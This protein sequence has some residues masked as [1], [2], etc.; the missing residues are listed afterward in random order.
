MNN[1]ETCIHGGVSPINLL[2]ELHHSQAGSGRHR[3]P[4][5]AY[6]QGFILGSSKQWISYSDYCLSLNNK[7]E[8]IN[9]SIAPSNI[10]KSLGGNQGGT[11]RHKCTNCAFKDGFQVGILE[12]KIGNIK[13]E[14]VETPKT[15]LITK[16]HNFTAFKNTDFIE[17]ELKNKRL[18]YLGELFVIQNEKEILIQKGRKDLADKIQHSSEEVG[19][20]LGYDIL[21][22]E[23]NGNEKFIEVKTTRGEINR[24]FYLTK[25]EVEFSKINKSNY[26]LHR[27][28][29]FDTNLNVGKFYEIQGDIN[30]ALNLDAILYLA[31][32]I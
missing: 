28:F 25:N 5:C 29:D 6:E 3:C 24:P 17:K 4:T 2:K 1:N 16:K 15:K 9:G 7:E 31:S 27:I 21:S 32:P 8:C 10:L 19:D 14:L 13:L 23:E 18:G 22:F 26:Y 30:I 11:G 20:G 12:S